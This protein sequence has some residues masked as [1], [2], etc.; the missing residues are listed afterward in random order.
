MGWVLIVLV[1]AAELEKLPKT[2]RSCGSESS[3]L[4]KSNSFTITTMVIIMMILQKPSVTPTVKSPI[5][6]EELR[7]G[8]LHSMLP[9][10]LL[11]PFCKNS[12]SEWPAACWMEKLQGHEVETQK[13]AANQ[14]K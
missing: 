10:L 13:L 8:N 1:A 2:I 12:E 6:R 9:M 7:N 14:Y 11:Y 3:S 5:S 4:P